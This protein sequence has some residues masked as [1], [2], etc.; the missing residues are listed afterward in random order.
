L[1]PTV[2][3]TVA[4][5]VTGLDV[6][7]DRRGDPALVGMAARVL[8]ALIPTV[9]IW[10]LSRVT[11]LVGPTGVGKT[12]TIA[13]LAAAAVRERGERVA[14]F[15]MDLHR[16]AA[17]E[18]LRGFADLIGAPL[19]VL[20]TKADLH[21]AL[22]AHQDRSRIWIDTAGCGPQAT[23]AL[24][25]LQTALAELPLATLLCVPAASRRQDLEPIASA[26][27]ALQPA[28]WIATKWDE[29]RCPGEVVSHCI[30]TG[31]PLALL[32]DGQDVPDDLLPAVAA[33]LACALLEPT[34]ET[35]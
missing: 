34:S 26:Y 29:T 19:E 8:A 32:T 4:R 10:S 15:T 17:V 28:A 11:A 14:L 9:D 27:A 31:A 13:K 12:T 2:L 16:V 30:E 24:R 5:A 20:F 33:D 35:P 25:G 3:E 7:I 21:R 18:Q 1:S 22:H 23:A 6:R